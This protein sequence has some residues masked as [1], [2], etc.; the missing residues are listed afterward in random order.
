M[1]ERQVL[2]GL[3]TSH[4]L[5]VHQACWEPGGLC[6]SLHS[7]RDVALW[8]CSLGWWWPRVP[9]MNFALDADGDHS[10]IRES[11]KDAVVCTG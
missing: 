7:P 2:D 8:V 9:A 3:T 4:L 1:G 6:R 5:A 10:V 11:D